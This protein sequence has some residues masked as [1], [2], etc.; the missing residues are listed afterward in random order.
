MKRILITYATDGNYIR[1]A[2]NLCNSALIHGF[3]EA[4]IYTQ[5][6]ID[7]N[8]KNKCDNILSLPRGGGYWLWKP[9]LIL[10]TLN[11]KCQDDDIV[12]YCDSQYLFIENMNNFIDT[13]IANSPYNITIS[14]NKPNEPS[15]PEHMWSKGDAFYII[16]GQTVAEDNTLQAWAGF[17]AMKKT[18]NSNSNCISVISEWLSYA[19]DIRCISDMPSTSIGNHKSFVENRHDQTVLSLVAK[20]YSIPFFH[21]PC[22][23]L[24]NIRV[25]YRY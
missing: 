20:K 19:Q 10:K 25:P 9:Y 13:H 6:N 24:Q 3:D 4:Y 23:Y 2:T 12:V 16:N 7:I 14:H 22:R 18:S 21:F 5:N 11:E 8:F 1:H 17:V 15:Y